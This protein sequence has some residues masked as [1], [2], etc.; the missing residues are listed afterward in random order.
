MDTSMKNQIEENEYFEL[1]KLHGKA[2]SVG[3]YKNANKYHRKLHK[4]YRRQVEND[5]QHFFFNYLKDE[6]DFIALWSA[7]FLLTI[8][9]E[10]AES[11]LIELS[12]SSLVK[13]T[14]DMT[15]KMW[16]QGLLDLI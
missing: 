10:Q 2:F 9:P 5:R 12:N 14:A 7:I 8:E 16:H 15:L 11:K 6:D 1:C 3:D 13:Q 4:F